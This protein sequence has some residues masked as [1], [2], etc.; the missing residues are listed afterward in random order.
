MILGICQLILFQESRELDRN[1]PSICRVLS[2]GYIYQDTLVG[3]LPPQRD[4]RSFEFVTWLP[5]VSEGQF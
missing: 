3:V 5:C 2:S 4:K 1:L